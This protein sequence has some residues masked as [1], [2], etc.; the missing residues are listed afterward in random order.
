MK[1]AEPQDPM[2]LVGVALPGGSMHAMATC[3]VEEYLMLGFNDQQL[4]SLFRRPCFAATHGIYRAR[5]E[6]YVR[7]LIRDVRHRYTETYRAGS[8]TDE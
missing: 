4:L 6:D 2:E 7:A 5:G 8:N 1:Q 3:L